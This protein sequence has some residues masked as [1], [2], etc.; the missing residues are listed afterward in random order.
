[1]PNFS[2]GLKLLVFKY[3]LATESEELKQQKK[4]CRVF[5]TVENP[6]IA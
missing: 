2:A 1:M 5:G 4:L 3:R 6:K